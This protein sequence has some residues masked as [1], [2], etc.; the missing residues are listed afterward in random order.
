MRTRDGAPSRRTA[1][2]CSS[3]TR[4]SSSTARSGSPPLPARHFWIYDSL[5]SEYAGF[6]YGYSVANQDALVI[7]EAS[8]ATS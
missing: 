2:P 3:T 6:E 4:P 1:T 5:L 7:W 8:S